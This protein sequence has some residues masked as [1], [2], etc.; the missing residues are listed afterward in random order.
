MAPTAPHSDPDDGTAPHAVRRKA[1]DMPRSDEPARAVAPWVRTR[2]RTAPWAAAALALL[3]RHRYLA[4]A[5]PR[6]AERAETR[7]R[8][9]NRSAAP[10]S[11]A[12]ER[13]AAP[14]SRPADGGRG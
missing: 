9:T 6:A 11:A 10:R 2:L 13:R 4:A 14:Q 5:L 7:A 3:V 12:L 1:P 8:G